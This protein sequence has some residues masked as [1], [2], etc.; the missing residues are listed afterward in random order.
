MRVVSYDIFVN[1][2]ISFIFY[3]AFRGF[4]MFAFLGFINLILNTTPES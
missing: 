3:I 1:T 4:L 2:I